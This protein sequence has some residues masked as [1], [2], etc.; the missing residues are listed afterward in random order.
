MWAKVTLWCRHSKAS[1][2]KVG[3]PVRRFGKPIN[4]SGRLNLS[5]LLTGFTEIQPVIARHGSTPPLAG[6]ALKCQ[7]NKSPRL[8]S[9]TQRQVSEVSATL[10]YLLLVQEELSDKSPILVISFTSSHRWVTLCCTLKT[11][12][13]NTDW[14]QWTILPAPSKK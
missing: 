6:N 7:V 8:H 2:H 10:H 9:V 4:F 11:Q 12:I 14:C 5:W 13:T 1:K 3:G